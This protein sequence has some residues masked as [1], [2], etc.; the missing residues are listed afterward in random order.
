[1]ATGSPFQ[2]VTLEDGRHFIPSQCNNMYIFPGIGLAASIS[3][4]TTITNKMLYLAAEACTNSMTDAE[5]AEGR[6]FPHIMRIREV[7]MNVAIAVINEG[8]KEGLTTKIKPADIERG[9]P[10]LVKRKMYDP[11]YAPLIHKKN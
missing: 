2:P 5:L 9:I 10:N 11:N 3:G 6:T 8:I 1:M 4:V 7:S